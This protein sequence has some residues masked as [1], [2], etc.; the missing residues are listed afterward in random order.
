MISLSGNGELGITMMGVLCASVELDRSWE[1]QLQ[2][3]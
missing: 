1:F 3:E 2:G